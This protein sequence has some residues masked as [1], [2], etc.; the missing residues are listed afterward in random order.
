[1][2]S[3]NTNGRKPTIRRSMSWSVSSTPMTNSDKPPEEKKE[4]VIPT[5]SAV[6]PNGELVE[7]VY[8]PI[9]RQTQFVCGTK[10]AWRY[11]E[12]V[13]LS[14]TERLVPFRASNNLVK[15]DV[16]LFPE[17]PED[18]GHEADL[19]SLVRSFI[20]RYVDVSAEFAEMSTYYVLFPWLYDAF[21]EVPYVRVRG[22]Y[23]SGKT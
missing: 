20:H 19:V 21:S 12:S 6:L 7:M 14:P 22:G 8:D 9:K 10:D 5:A 18:Y 15:H 1:S 16:V 17:E 4:V 2:H 3:F 11:E 23:G 13:L